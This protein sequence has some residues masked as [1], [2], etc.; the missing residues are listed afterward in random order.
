MRSVWILLLSLGFALVVLGC[1]DHR[2]GTK[3]PRDAGAAAGSGGTCGS[4][5][6]ANDA[7]VANDAAV[8]S[9]AARPPEIRARTRPTPVSCAGRPTDFV[10]PGPQTQRQGP[11]GACSVPS[12]CT[13]HPGGHCARFIPLGVSTQCLYDECYDDDD[14]EPGHVCECSGGPVGTAW[15]RCVAGGC[16]VDE[17]CEEDQRCAASPNEM[18]GPTFPISGYHCIGSPDDECT[19]DPSCP[20]GAY[21]AFSRTRDRWHCAAGM[22]AGGSAAR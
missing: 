21:C 17:D 20:L 19:G 18:C 15:N 10:P 16:T 1:A 6:F 14:C 7:D 12:D 11:D 9:D 8:A 13:K 5:S 22:C 4:G 3:Q 2:R